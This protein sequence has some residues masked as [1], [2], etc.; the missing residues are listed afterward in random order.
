VRQFVR[1]LEGWE[2][3]STREF[4]QYVWGLCEFIVAVLARSTDSKA[5]IRKSNRGRLSPRKPP[6]IPRLVG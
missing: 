5:G 2:R 3:P 6:G 1:R 4:I